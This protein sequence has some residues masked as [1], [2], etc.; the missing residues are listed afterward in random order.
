MCS[1]LVYFLRIIFIHLIACILNVQYLELSPV[2]VNGAFLGDVV[3]FQDLLKKS[4]AGSLKNSLNCVIRITFINEFT[5]PKRSHQHDYNA[6]AGLVLADGHHTSPTS[7]G[8]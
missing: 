4:H 6:E 3:I 8:S 1:Y 7:L 2:L 5:K